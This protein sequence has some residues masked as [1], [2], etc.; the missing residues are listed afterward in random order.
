MDVAD[1]VAMAAS[2][3]QAAKQLKEAQDQVATL[4]EQNAVLMSNVERSRNYLCLPD[5]LNMS[6]LCN[7]LNVSYPTLKPIVELP[8]FPKI[9]IG[10][11]AEFR[12]PKEAVREW[13]LRNAT[14]PKISKL[15][16]RIA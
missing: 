7:W 8:G 11:G 4:A 6:E 15:L 5:Y 3:Q 1:F 2:M 16:G 12:F 14:E 13:F 10:V 9:P